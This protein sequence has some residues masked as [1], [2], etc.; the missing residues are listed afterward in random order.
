MGAAVLGVPVKPTIKEVDQTGM[1]TKTLVR[2]DLWEVQTPQVSLS[3]LS[4]CTLVG[5]DIMVMYVPVCRMDDEPQLE[6]AAMLFQ[7]EICLLWFCG[8]TLL[9]SLHSN[10]RLP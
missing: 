7:H 6:V 9:L 4:A 10:L 8:L 2:A 5:R 1:V 3:W